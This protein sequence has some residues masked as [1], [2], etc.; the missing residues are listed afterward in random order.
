[1]DPDGV[2]RAPTQFNS[3]VDDTFFADTHDYIIR[4]VS[5]IVLAVYEVLGYPYSKVPDPLSREKLNTAFT[6][7]RPTLGYGVN[8][9]TMQV[10]ML[11]EKREQLIDTLNET[12]FRREYT[13]LQA[14]QLL[15]TLENATRYNRWARVLYC[16]LG[17]AF[18]RTLQAASYVLK[19]T[20][21]RTGR[22]EQLRAALPKHLERRFQ[23]LVSKDTA[24][25]LYRSRRSFPIT[26]EVLAEMRELTDFLQDRTNDFADYIGFL[27]PRDPAAGSHG[28]SSEIAT[29]GYS[30]LL[31][32]W[33]QILWSPEVLRAMALD[34][35]DDKYVHINLLEFVAI[36]LQIAAFIVRLQELPDDIRQSVFPDGV[37]V[38]PI[39]L[40]WCDNTSAQAWAGKVSTRSRRAQGLL[41]IYAALLREHNV[42]VNCSRI[43]TSENTVADI[44]SRPDDTTSPPYIRFLQ[45]YRKLDFL[46]T[47]DYF[48]PSQALISRLHSELCNEQSRP[49]PPLPEKLGRFVPA[50]STLS[51]IGMI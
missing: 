21:E 24:R 25:L 12:I 27:V 9:R 15:G 43:S 33:F 26:S 51:C 18:R 49:R 1:L 34:P 4:A 41:S 37:P 46:R 17:H 23:P 50:G 30:R 7:E 35:K 31:R 44:I 28:D 42:G 13:L 20:Y 38:Q 11:P 40:A 22:I 6:F 29:G 10:Y 36:I 5:A 48:L 45:T 2:R 39:L 3:W 47:Y 14:A 8:T 32:Y 19:R 16:A